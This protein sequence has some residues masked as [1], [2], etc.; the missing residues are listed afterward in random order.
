M[1][2]STVPACITSPISEAWSILLLPSVTPVHGYNRCGG[3]HRPSCY[4]SGCEPPHHLFASRCREVPAPQHT[5]TYSIP[6][7]GQF[8]KSGKLCTPVH[9]PNKCGYPLTLLPIYLCQV[10]DGCGSY[11]LAMLPAYMSKR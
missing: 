11:P 5:H 8:L 6:A 1:S 4:L 7:S 3:G 9:C 2:P 10:T